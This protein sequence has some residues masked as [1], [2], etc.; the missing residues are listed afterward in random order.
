MG[1]LYYMFNPVSNSFFP[2]CPFLLL[3]EL[4]CPGCGSQRAIHSL[5]HFDIVAA[6]KFN[7]LLVLSLPI[8]ALLI[9]AEFNRVKKPRLYSSLH[10]SF[11]IWIY[12]A[13]IIAWWIGRNIF[14]F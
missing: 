13:I 8:I 6:F 7:A 3:T 11:F 12:F 14:D 10:N 1:L 9:Y 2:K 5:L 4:K